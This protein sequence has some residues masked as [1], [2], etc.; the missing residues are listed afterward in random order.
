MRVKI[1][2]T[3][4]VTIPKE[5]RARLNTSFVYFAVEGDVITIRP[6]LDAAGSLHEYAGN[7][8]PGMTMSEIKEK[9]WE[10]AVREKARKT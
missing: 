1:T 10:E 7:A 2:R 9:A 4:Q 6:V 8:P 3:G 5:I